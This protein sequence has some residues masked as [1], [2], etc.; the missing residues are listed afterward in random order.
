MSAS[1]KLDEAMAMRVKKLA[2]LRQRSP[3]WI[4]RTAI[5]EYV[6]REEARE[7]FKKEALASWSEYQETGQHQSGEELR[8][9]LKTWGDEA[10]KDA[11][12]CHG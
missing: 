8:E 11:P 9:W 7:S 10:E 1:V 5:E 4:M 2:D 12:D 3:H 6:A